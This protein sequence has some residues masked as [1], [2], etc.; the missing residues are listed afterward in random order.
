MTTMIKRIERA[1]MAEDEKHFTEDHGRFPALSLAVLMEIREPSEAM[2]E[3]GWGASPAQC[4][5]NMVD[6]ALSKAG[7]SQ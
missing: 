2:I 4:W 7:K 6:V 3:A 5:R 1:I